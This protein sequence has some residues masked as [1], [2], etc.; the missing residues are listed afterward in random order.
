MPNT[1]LRSDSVSSDIGPRSNSIDPVGT[2]LAVTM[3]ASLDPEG[4]KL[5]AC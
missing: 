1:P 3:M 4:C 5:E 2:S